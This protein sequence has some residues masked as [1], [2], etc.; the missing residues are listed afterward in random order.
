MAITDIPELSDFNAPKTNA[1][2]VA[3]ASKQIAA[4]DFNELCQRVID[5]TTA[6]GLDD[7]T[8]SG[9]LRAGAA[10]SVKGR[11][12][13]TNGAIADIAAATDGHVLRRS[14]T[15]IGFGTVA[16]DG[17][18]DG[19]ITG[20]KIVQ[21]GTIDV[22]AASI[23]TSGTVDGR[24][25]SADGTVLDSL[26]IGVLAA[27]RRAVSGNIT[28]DSDDRVLLISA[29]ADI[30]LPSASDGRIVILKK[31]TASSI[32]VN[33]VR[34]GSEKIE[35][36]SATYAATEFASTLYVAL[37]LYCDGTDWWIL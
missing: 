20:A 1:F 21:S 5:V 11:A 36:A 2:P 23:T 22:G 29:S 35:N 26:K 15:S 17:I 12:S 8:T 6:V 7:G 31:T 28:I 9:S 34:A 33:V 19:A 27:G 10:L 24:D 3:D 14:G 16:T 37:A 18:A 32:T 4:D 13:N 30:T 25:V